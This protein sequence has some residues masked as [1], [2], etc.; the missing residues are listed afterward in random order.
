MPPIAEGGDKQNDLFDEP[1]EDDLLA[2]DA[3]GPES[4]DVCGSLWL[5]RS[6]GAA[7]KAELN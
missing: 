2:G 1:E 4:R 3:H 7:L 5:R 6:Y